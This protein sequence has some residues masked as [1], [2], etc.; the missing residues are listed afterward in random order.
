VRRRTLNQGGTR[1]LRAS[2]VIA[3]LAWAGC[4]G[5]GGQEV[6]PDGDSSVFIGPESIVVVDSVDLAS[7][8]SLSG[9][10]EPERVS[11]I[12]AEVGGTVLQTMAE[13]GQSVTRGTQLARIDDTAI[14]DT[15]LSARIGVTTAEQ[16]T[17]VA[18][19]NAERAERLA[20]AGAI[21]ER[22]L[23][24]ARVAATTAEAQLADAKARLALAQKQL[25]STEVRSTITGIVSERAVNAG[26]VVSP[27]MPLFT[28][29]DPT[30]MRLEAAV[31][32]SAIGMLRIGAPVD[33]TVNGYGDRTFHGEILRINPT[34]D[35]ATGQVGV[36]VAIPNPGG[37]LVGGVYAQGRVGAESK[38]AL[39]APF[40]AVRT[41]GS[42]ASVL[43]IRNGLVERVDVQAGI[44]D[45]Q[46]ERIEIIAG[47]AVGDTLLAGAAQGFT[48]GTPV[49]MRSIADP[50]ATER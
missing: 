37:Q 20:E 2:A 47:L 48:P 1:L 45:E 34:V 32:A 31:A 7:G 36:I 35:P 9:T 6:E 25:Q 49:R 41:D 4:G 22:E 44:R 26:D 15:Y 5:S 50:P 19:R 43:R 33:F 24:S 14:R 16:A 40:N 18:R 38:R 27:G 12:R 28:V 46:N 39:A 3:A 8:P 10:L 23:E 29:V 30:G 13:A 17:E 11:A 42:T 21:A